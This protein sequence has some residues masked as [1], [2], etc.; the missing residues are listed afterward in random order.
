M[1]NLK[2][3]VMNWYSLFLNNFQMKTT[4][5]QKAKIGIFTLAGL[6]VLVIGIF[7]IGNKKNLFGDT[8]PIYG[9][10]RSVGGL[11]VG[12]NVRFAGINV[13]TVESIYIINDS[14]VRVDMRM[15]HRVHQFLKND[16]VASISSDGLMGDK[17]VTIT[18]GPAG[19]KIIEKGGQVM[20]VNPVDYDKVITRVM[21]VIDNAEAITTS[22]AGISG[23]INSGKG[24]LGKL[25][26]SN[27]LS[28]GLDATVNSA[29]ETMQTA[30][31]GV[32][33]FTENMDAMKHNFLLKGYYKKKAREKA[34]KAQYKTD[35]TNGTITEPYQS[36]R[37]HRKEER[38]E[39]KAKKQ[40]DKH[41]ATDTKQQ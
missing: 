17:L 32:E 8:F 13:G 38:E 16:A 4:A 10:F 39:K 20:T 3:Q 1:Q 34:D 35:S 5:S 21:H 37:Q 26:Y 25:L 31:K 24:S 11:Q 19:G 6:L 2:N 33:G 12:N 29:K 7:V 41:P 15:Q 18:P 9:T 36:R 22:L 30:Q 23:Q 14:N 28:N 40:E 27:E